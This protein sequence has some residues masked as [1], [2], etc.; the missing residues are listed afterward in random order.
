[1]EIVATAAERGEWTA[2]HCKACGCEWSHRRVVRCPICGNPMRPVYRP[3][4]G[5][6]CWDCERCRMELAKY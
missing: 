1:M 4:G 3:S 5:I 6:G 2:F